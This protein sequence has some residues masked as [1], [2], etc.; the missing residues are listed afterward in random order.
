MSSLLQK[1]SRRGAAP[2]AT[3]QRARFKAPK[4][5]AVMMV[6]GAIFVAFLLGAVVGLGAVQLTIAL[7]GLLVF[8]PIL[9]LINTRMLL[10]LLLVT[11]FVL[12]GTAEYFFNMRLATWMATM[13][14]GLFFIRAILELSNQRGPK[15]VQSRQFPGAGTVI[16]MGSL[17]LLCY[18]FSLALGQAT[19]FQIVS[20]VRFTLP[21]FGVLFALYW[22]NWQETGITRLW[23]MLVIFTV[24]QVPVVLYQHFFMI[25]SIGWDG[26][27]GTF[28]RGMSAILVIFSL[29][30]LMFVLARW[31]RGLTSMPVV[32]GV[33][34]CVIAVILLGEVKAALF[35][36]P[37]GVLW[38]LRRRVLRNVVAFATFSCLILAFTAGTYTAYKAMYWKDGV[39]RDETIAEKLDY[40]GGYV[41]DPNNINYRTGEVS[42]GASL[43]L[44]YRD[45]VSATKERLIGY[46]PGASAIS[47]STGLGVVAMRYRPLG[48]AATAMAT[49][50]W[51]VGLL[52]A[53]CYLAFIGS[54]I[55]AGIRFLKRNGASPA[56]LSVVD[57]AVGTLLLLSS[58]IVYNRAML[59]EPTVQL[60]CFLSLGS[61]VQCCRYYDRRPE[62]AKA[63]VPSM[64]VPAVKTA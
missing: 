48:I 50:L 42:R 37:V 12:Q 13:L 58:T 19:P 56:M 62:T 23:V 44:W 61:I 32:V 4:A 25:S 53:L 35:W 18:F 38:I 43:M 64:A 45:S 6:L 16:A 9:F 21:M 27:S 26:V 28:G 22:F 46:G 60:L 36:L 17:Y 14:C 51:D 11:V 54:G 30:T 55:F 15:P 59:D 1:L 40:M 3:A 29:S 52:G 49:L 8:L 39:T 20:T 10:P 5:S 47:S 2:G 63:A 33:T 34:L 7:A 41:V 31:S 24:L 57:T